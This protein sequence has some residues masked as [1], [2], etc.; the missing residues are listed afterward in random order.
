MKG[1]VHGSVEA[2]VHALDEFHRLRRKKASSMASDVPDEEIRV[3][4]L[5]SGVGPFTSSD[6]DH[7]KAAMRRLDTST[8]GNN[9]FLL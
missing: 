1:D 9:D 8:D 2:V 6:V 5:H 7:I 3:N 4:V